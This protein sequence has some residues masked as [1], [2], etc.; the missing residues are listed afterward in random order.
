[1]IHTLVFLIQKLAINNATD[2]VNLCAVYIVS[3]AYEQL[4]GEKTV[5]KHVE[6]FEWAG[7]WHTTNAKFS[8]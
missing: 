1:M 7:S 8:I 6:G 5:L 2:N 4:N 3:R